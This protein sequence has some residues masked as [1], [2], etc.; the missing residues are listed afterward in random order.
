MELSNVLWLLLLIFCLFSFLFVFVF[1]KLRG[2]NKQDYSLFASKYGY[3][4]DQAQEEGLFEQMRKKSSANQSVITFDLAINPYISR[5]AD[6]QAYPFGR[7]YD[8]RVSSVISGTYAGVSFRAFNYN[9]TSNG[10]SSDLGGSF[11]VVM[12]KEPGAHPV[13]LPEGVFYEKGVLCHYLP[14]FLMVD[15]IHKRIDKLARLI[16]I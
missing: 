6:F 13:N 15:D 1:R 10:D 11:S 16:G 9:F 12:L 3:H 2:E 4:Y 5:Y 8:K 14:G 7:G